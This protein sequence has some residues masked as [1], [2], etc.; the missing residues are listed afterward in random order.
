VLLGP[1]EPVLQPVRGRRQP[2]PGRERLR[3]TRH[4]VPVSTDPLTTIDDDLELAE[5]DA[6]IQA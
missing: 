3:L 6:Y 2:L 5:P 4:S 1:V